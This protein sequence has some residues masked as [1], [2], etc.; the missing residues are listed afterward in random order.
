LQR[1]GIIGCVSS[2]R[3]H[4]RRRSSLIA[5]ALSFLLHGAAFLL[6]AAFVGE[7]AIVRLENDRPIGI[8]IAERRDA[9]T[10]R[11]FDG[12]AANPAASVLGGESA[13]LAGTNDS[14]FDA[15]A[16][17]LIDDQSRPA[18]PATLSA[19]DGVHVAAATDLLRTGSAGGRAAGRG[20]IS[21]DG[22][23]LDALAAERQRLRGD[24]PSFPP[25]S[26]ELFGGPATAGR[27]FVFL[28]D[29]SKSMTAQG[30]NAIE[31]ARRELRS[32]LAALTPEHRFQIIAYN[33]KTLFVNE[34]MMLPA[35][36][37]NKQQADRFLAELGGFG[38]T[39]HEMALQTAIQLQPDVIY[40]LTDGGD[41]YL[42]DAQL[43]RI[44]QR[45]AGRVV[46][47]CV[48]FVADAP[49]VS[50]PFLERLAEQNRG[51]YRVVSGS[52]H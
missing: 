29:R 37:E 48:Q 4:P 46:I 11:Y 5:S 24:V 44:R 18:G 12:A 36:E 19:A 14:A 34:R 21:S 26:V 27:S 13:A 50:N 20:R 39:Q 30:M 22:P 1:F 3:E 40:L 47:H 52:K 10:A 43:A 17:A 51:T 45:A 49:P 25:A 32:A 2:T 9:Q 42:N 15:A 33:F 35:T 38:A 41:P 7:P 31:I 23:D 16:L 28:I 8:V 6:L